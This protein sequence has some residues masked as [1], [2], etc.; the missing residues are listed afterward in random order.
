MVL[1][2]SLQVLA[3]EAGRKHGIR[4]NTISAGQYWAQEQ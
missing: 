3:F 2:V 1:V 4:V